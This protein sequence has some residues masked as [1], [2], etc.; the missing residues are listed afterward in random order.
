MQIFTITALFG[1]Q[2][3]HPRKKTP[4]NRVKII[5]NNFKKN[6]HVDTPHKYLRSFPYNPLQVPSTL[7]THKPFPMTG[8][9]TGSRAQFCNISPTSQEATGT[10]TNQI[11]NRHQSQSQLH[12]KPH[13]APPRLT[14]GPNSINLHCRHRREK[15]W[16]QA[17]GKVDRRLK[18]RR[19]E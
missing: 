11:K 12:E 17:D 3:L 10:L 16:L 13:H 9:N 19:E 8:S 2:T 5:N 6:P 1:L 7:P 4:S 18:R 15:T 14:S